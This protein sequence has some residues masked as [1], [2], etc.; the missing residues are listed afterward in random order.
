[1]TERWISA[2]G[3]FAI[4]GI[5]YLL[6]RNRKRV[7]VRALAGGTLLQVVLALAIL[8]TQLGRDVF[9]S[10][11]SVVTTILG[12]V[13]KGSAFVF[14]PN[15]A[16]F[17]IA[18]KVLPT[19][20]FFSALM[21]VLYHFGV[22][23]LVV[24]G[25]GWVM[26]RT[27]GTSGAESL[28]AAANVFV[29]QTEAPLVVKPYLDSMTRS[30]L[31][32]LMVGGFATVAGGVLAAYAGMGV[33]PGHLVTASVISAPAALMIAKLLEPEVAEPKT[34]GT[35]KIEVPRESK[36]FL[37]AITIGT[38]DGVKLAINVG[39][40][41]LVFTAMIAMINF[42]IQD[43]FGSEWSIEGILGWIFLPFA[44]LMGIESKD[45]EA[46]GQLLGMKTVF[47]EFLAYETMQSWRADEAAFKLSERS[48]T[49]ATYALC[50]F[51]NFAS[52]GIQIG[53]IGALAPGRQAELASIAF[54]S[55]IG[56]AFAAF[57]TA[58][59][60]GVIL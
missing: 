38:T 49:I 14:G 30:E 9:D 34:L 12:F 48:E 46:V 21:S 10:M 11:G 18:F 26:V 59:I 57:S 33:N 43:V 32:S 44:W 45:C 35:V 16:D 7:S 53:G 42:G 55:M 23:Q 22:A 54:R 29:G 25:M 8:K 41:L 39:A 47:T 31:M 20:V 51:A 37:H 15:F 1:M 28:A 50:G 17:F 24:R 4:L 40:M 58:C 2:F 60:A 13:D 19:I 3:F 27:L 52:I 6:G 5:T 56:G 36:N